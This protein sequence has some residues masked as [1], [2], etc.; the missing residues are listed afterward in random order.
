[1]S[2]GYRCPDCGENDPEEIID[3]DNGKLCRS[4]GCEWGEET[5]HFE[6]E[7]EE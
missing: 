6:D 4:C 7:D 1:M 3:W 5:K 2:D